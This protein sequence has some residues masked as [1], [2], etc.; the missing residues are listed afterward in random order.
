M[1]AADP[2]VVIRRYQVSSMV[3]ILSLGTVVLAG[4]YFIALAGVSL[5]IPA[6]AK[7]FLLGFADSLQKHFAELFLRLLV[8]AAFVFHAPQT[9]LPA[10]FSSFGWVLLLTTA[11]LLVIPWKWHRRFAQYSVPKATQYIKLIGLVS[12]TLGAFILAAVLRSLEGTCSSEE[13]ISSWSI[14]ASDSSLT[15]NHPSGD[16]YNLVPE[17]DTRFSEDWLTLIFNKSNEESVTFLIEAGRVRNI[18]FSRVE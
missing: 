9:N 14:T 17:S 3:E 8:G 12:L 13:L 10:V 7:R 2:P 1:L 5:F 16:V 11:A 15:L 4:L 18:Q 6:H